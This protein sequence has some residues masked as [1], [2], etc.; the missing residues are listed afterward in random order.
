MPLNVYHTPCLQW[1]NVDEYINTSRLEPGLQ[2]RPGF[3]RQIELMLQTGKK[4]EIESLQD[5]HA[6]RFLSET[7]LPYKLSTS[8]WL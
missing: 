4:A 5:E 1:G 6:A 3:V 8:S 2:V 7:Y